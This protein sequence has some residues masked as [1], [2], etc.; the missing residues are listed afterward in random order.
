[1]PDSQLT[2]SWPCPDCGHDNDAELT[3]CR[4]CHRL[5]HTDET[6]PVT[7]LRPV[8]SV[9]PDRP[10][11]P[12]SDIPW[13]AVWLLIAISSFIFLFG[14]TSLAIPHEANF[15]AGAILVIVITAQLAYGVAWLLFDFQ[16][17]DATPE[18]DSMLL[19][20]LRAALQRKFGD[21]STALVTEL[22]SRPP[23]QLRALLDAIEPAESLDDL[24]K[25][26]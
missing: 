3:A 1:M 17:V 8:S 9:A 16:R 6:V 11:D 15:L 25:L 19:R 5:R 2:Q 7:T 24:R 26:L 22:Q 21:S 12:E 13:Q 23:S 20:Q 4:R 14:G 10:R 18:D